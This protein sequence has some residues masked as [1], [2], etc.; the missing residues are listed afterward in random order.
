MKIDRIFA[1]ALIFMGAGT[2]C[3]SC[4]KKAPDAEPPVQEV[5][6]E[7]AAVEEI[8]VPVESFAKATVLSE[9]TQLCLWGRD[10]KMHKISTLLNT[11]RTE[12]LFIDEISDSRTYNDTEYLHAIYDHCDYWI[13]GRHIAV[14]SVPAV[15]IENCSLY[16]DS[17][18]QLPTDGR[19][20]PLKFGRMIALSD[21]EEDTTETSEKIFYYDSK[22]DCVK[23]AWI[24]KGLVSSREDDVVVMKVVEGLRVTKRATPR[25]ELFKRAAKYDPCPKVKAALNSQMVEKVENNYQ[26]VLNALP[27]ARIKVN[28]KELMT[29]DQ[30]KDPFQ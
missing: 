15:V 4:I 10:E 7:E 21:L 13:S 5:P 30:S 9:K 12:I 16:A 8:P 18:L 28:V 11:D 19:N 26:D 1:A 24:K 6:S 23:S 27:G 20:S 2:L 17:N 14:N 3:L 25:N 22:E 29:V